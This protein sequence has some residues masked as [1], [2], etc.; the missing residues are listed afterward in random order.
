MTLLSA[1][2]GAVTKPVPWSNVKLLGVTPAGEHIET[3][4]REYILQPGRTDAQDGYAAG[5]GRIIVSV[6]RFE[7]DNGR[8]LE[9]GKFYRLGIEVPLG[10]WRST[11]TIKPEKAPPAPVDIL[12]IEKLY[13]ARRETVVGTPATAALVE[14]KPAVRGP[15]AIIERLAAKGITLEL[16]AGRLLVK[17]PRGRA[18][19][20]DLTAIRTA[21]RLLV[22][23]L[24]G[25]PLRCELPHDGAAPEAE[26]IVALDIAA[27]EDCAR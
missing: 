25:T 6:P 9:V 1:I 21:E 11:P 4:G 10:T 12:A 7:T 16:H 18:T 27:C 14:G 26:T 2:R 5:P 3:G 23:Y 15:A 24:E 22:A 19:T 20:D 17:A 13:Q 8:R